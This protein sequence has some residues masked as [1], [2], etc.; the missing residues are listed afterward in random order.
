MKNATK[1]IGVLGIAILSAFQSCIKEPPT[2]PKNNT[3]QD[4]KGLRVVVLCEGNFLWNNASVDLYLPDSQ[5]VYNN[6]FESANGNDLG[7]VLQSALY[8]QGKLNLVVNNSGKIVQVNPKTF[9]LIQSKSG[10][11]SPRY[12]IAAGDKFLISDIKSPYI[13]LLDTQSLQKVGEIQIP[14]QIVAGESYWS[15]TM[16]VVDSFVF[17]AIESGKL[18]VI[19]TKSKSRVLI[20]AGKGAT[21][22]CSDAQKRVWLL[23]S[24]N[25]QSVLYQYNGVTL[26][27]EQQIPIFPNLSNASATRM[28][29]PVLGDNLYLLVNGKIATI[30][31]SS[32]MDPQQIRFV[33]ISGLKNA[34]ALNVNPFN[35][36]IYVGDAVDYVSNGKVIVLNYAGILK[37]QFN[38]G[39]IPTDFVFIK[40]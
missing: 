9:K 17:V 34:Y 30:P 2:Q 13:T 40:D 20:E 28:S 21:Q 14:D 38:S 7:D 35:G 11:S 39:V 4:V 22:L 1:W 36:D 29:L 18:M 23:C 37:H 25:G 10:F 32:Q 33:E 26:N 31:I 16:T 6:V 5:K 19:N 3:P 8:H 15:E 12:M 24:Q 27:Q